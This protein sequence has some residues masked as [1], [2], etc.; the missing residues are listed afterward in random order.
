MSFYPRDRRIW[1]ALC[2]LV[3]PS[4]ALWTDFGFDAGLFSRPKVLKGPP[5]WCICGEMRVRHPSG[6]CSDSHTQNQTHAAVYGNPYVPW[7]TQW[8][9]LDRRSVGGGVAQPSKGSQKTSLWCTCGVERVCPPSGS[10]ENC[11]T[12]HRAPCAAHVP[13]WAQMKPLTQLRGPQG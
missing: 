9:S 2:S 6:P 3:V 11:L 7:W 4:G 1:K 5:F 10:A 8:C 13:R 12:Q